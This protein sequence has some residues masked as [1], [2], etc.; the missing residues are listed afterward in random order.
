MQ[1]VIKMTIILNFGQK[2]H[3]HYLEELQLYLDVV[4]ALINYLISWDGR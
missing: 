1:F 2:L 3:A 4:I